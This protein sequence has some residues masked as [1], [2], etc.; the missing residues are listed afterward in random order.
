M[1]TD[2]NSEKNDKR[3]GFSPPSISL[4]KGGGAMRGIGEKFAANPVT[5]TGSMTVP[6]AVSPGR[7]GFGPQL[8][9]SYDSGSG[10]GPFGF[11]WNLSLPSITRKTDKGLP[12]YQDADES[13]IFILSGAEDLVPL[14]VKNNGTWESELALNRTIN[15]ITYSVRRY[16]PRIEGLFARIERWSNKTDP[17]DVSWRSI[18]KDNITTWYGKTKNSR[19]SDPSDGSH[20]FS[21][22]I[23]QSYDDKGNSII[24]E[25]AEE[26]PDRIFEDQQGK[27]IS[28]I[29]EK[30][31]DKK[32]RSANRYIKRIKYGNKKPNRDENWEATDPSKLPD[33]LFE[34]VFD[35]EE[36]H[37]T[38]EKAADSSHHDYAIVSLNPPA[39]STWEV[40]QDPFSTYKA[41]FEIRTYRLC[42]R[43]LMFHHFK[44]ELNGIEDY[45]VKSTEFIYDQSPVATFITSIIQSGYRFDDDKMKYI[46]KTLPPLEFKYSKPIINDDVNEIDEE[47]LQNLPIGIDG[48]KYQLID[49]DGEGISG[50]LTEQA[51]AWYYKPNLGNGSFG[52]IQE[53][54]S[55]P[56]LADLNS[57]RQQLLDLAGDGQLDL[58]DFHG[59]VSG[60]YERTTDEK[61]EN[62]KSFES[63]PNIKWD[64][65]NL[66]F[67]DLN[68]DGHADILI[69]ENEVLRWYPSLAE[70]GFG[71]PYQ[72][73]IPSDEEQGPRLVFADG[74]QSIYLADMS[75]SGIAITRILNGEI[76]YWPNL[77]YGKFGKKVTMDNSPWFDS[78]DQFDQKR[79]RIADIDGSG[80]TDIIY[81]HSDGVSL[82]FNQ[83]GNGWSDKQLLKSFPQVDNLSSIMTADILGDG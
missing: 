14:L 46:K 82:Y 54:A 7:S 63:L 72:T 10:N 65:P 13:D 78:A 44:D 66:R 18:S 71:N 59:P 48:S 4:P 34:V 52:A 57:G 81:L 75:G 45:L 73:F 33:W 41:G 8:S 19:I 58:V 30:N 17:T 70:K 38:E 24:Y 29:H 16:R 1:G 43:V 21:W 67:V 11:G 62:F 26:N 3:T 35:Y 77:G 79:I 61:W 27:I 23:C 68:G 36:G 55:K 47:S 80:T 31:R 83:S 6:I 20:I 76:S 56:S 50:L 15:G 28:S 25:Y 74:T 37:F 32:S 51:E 39:G 9:L 12:K 69:T 49:L 53:V 5:G 64:D 60:F 40:R 22:L 42:H 2:S